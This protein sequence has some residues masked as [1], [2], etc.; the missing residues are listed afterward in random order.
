LP[1]SSSFF[2]LPRENVFFS[3]SFLLMH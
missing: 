1:S 2:F 3:F